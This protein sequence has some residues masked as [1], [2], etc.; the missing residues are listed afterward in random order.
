MSN[1]LKA[2]RQIL[3][4]YLGFLFLLGG[5]VSVVMPETD[6]ETFLQNTVTCINIKNAK[7]AAWFTEVTSHG[8]NHNTNTPSFFT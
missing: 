7:H 8:S 5:L 6:L 2:T 3:P 4:L 1:D